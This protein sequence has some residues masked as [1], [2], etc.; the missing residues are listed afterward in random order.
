MNEENV[1]IFRSYLRVLLFR[2][3]RNS[4]NLMPAL[5]QP[6]PTCEFLLILRCEQ[7]HAAARLS[8]VV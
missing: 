3:R 8:L 4:L 1:I 2:F 5:L 6:T 7:D